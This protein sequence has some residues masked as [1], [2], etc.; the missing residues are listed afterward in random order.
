MGV[1]LAGQRSC[2]VGPSSPASAD[3]P[4]PAVAVT[5]AQRASYRRPITAFAPLRASGVRLPGTRGIKPLVGAAFDGGDRGD[6]N[7][8]TQDHNNV[9]EGK[10]PRNT[11]S[12]RDSWLSGRQFRTR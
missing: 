10:R 1:R 9:A 5:A 7:P 12:S 6:S 2:S 11:L 3:L 8:D 4:H